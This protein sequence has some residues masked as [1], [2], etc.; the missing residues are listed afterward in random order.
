MRAAGGAH[1]QVVKVDPPFT[2]LAHLGG[3]PGVLIRPPTKVEDRLQPIP[4]DQPGE[5]LDGLGGAID[6]LGLNDAEIPVKQGI[7][8]GS[9]R[10]D[11]QRG[12]DAEDDPAQSPSSVHPMNIYLAQSSASFPCGPGRGAT[13]GRSPFCHDGKARHG[14]RGRVE[15][16]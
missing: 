3:V 14:L 10:G 2:R 9:R 12:D 8:K 6:V 16:L 1:R 7:A 4:V 15:T 13:W 5:I 11:E